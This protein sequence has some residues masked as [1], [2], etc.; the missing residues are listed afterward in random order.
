MQMASNIQTHAS[1]PPPRP[2]VHQYA[3]RFSENIPKNPKKIDGPNVGVSIGMGLDRG[4]I[5]GPLD[6]VG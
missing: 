4:H 5:Q 1:E 3:S 2:V 6:F